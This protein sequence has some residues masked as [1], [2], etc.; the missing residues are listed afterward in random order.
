M[1]HIEFIE[2]LGGGA[3]IA[4][5]LTELAGEHVDREAVYR[6]KKLNQIPWRWRSLLVG[7]AKE[8]GVTLPEEFLPGVAA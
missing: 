2:A 4:E 6:W 5:R 7:I 8:Q 3:K 1:T